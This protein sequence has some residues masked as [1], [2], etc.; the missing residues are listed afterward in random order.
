MKIIAFYLPQ[1]YSFPENDKW[2]GKGFTEWTNTR[3][4]IAQFK[5]H[6]QPR[7]PF[8]KNYYNL[9]EKKNIEW[10]VKLAKENGVYGFCFYHYWFKGGK[11]LLEKPVELFL[12]NADLDIPFC[13]SWANEPW[14]RSWDGANK[15]VIMPQEYGE[16]SEWKQHFEYLLPYFKDKRYLRIDGKPVFVF[17]RPEIFPELDKMIRFWNTL[18]KN[19]GFE[20]LTWM[21]QGPQWCADVS[22]DSELIDYKIMYEPGFTGNISDKDVGFSFLMSRYFTKIRRKLDPHNNINKMS[23]R[24]YAK[25]IINRIPPS[26]KYIPG[27]FPDWDNTA[28]RGSDAN[29]FL[30][31]TPDV[32]RENLIK[33]IERTKEDYK[34]DIIFIN[35]WNEWAEGCYLEPDEK[36]GDGYLRAIKD[37]LIETDEW[38][39]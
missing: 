20:G 7:V 35:A 4:A 16:E 13:L 6:Y 28:R 14:T 5:G 37:A 27:F 2:W 12:N 21:I 26:E 10:Q 19:S 36:F 33:L 23:Y 18:A 9:T 39:S 38:E 34:K 32:F 15:A 3:K 29:V 31:S 24:A 22:N 30:G 11:Q 8:N 17:Y 25:N 1:F